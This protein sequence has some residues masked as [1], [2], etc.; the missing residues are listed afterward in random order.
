MSENTQLIIISI[1]I[2]ILTLLWSYL[3]VFIQWI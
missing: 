3:E 1:G 2:L